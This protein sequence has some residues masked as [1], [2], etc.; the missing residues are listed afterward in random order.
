[1]RSVIYPKSTARTN[2]TD[3]CII[4]LVYFINRFSK[5]IEK[6]IDLL[7]PINFTAFYFYTKYD[8]LHEKLYQAYQGFYCIYGNM[9][10]CGR[11]KQSTT[12]L[13]TC[14]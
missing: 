8:P 6:H 10:T 5:Y 13:E 9:A 11:A 3:T 4:D 12:A 7:L 14:S 2:S 1:M